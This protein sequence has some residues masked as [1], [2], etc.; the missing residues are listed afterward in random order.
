MLFF[1]PNIC[2]YLMFI[3][4][5]FGVMPFTL[6]YLLPPEIWVF[7]LPTFSP[8]PSEFQLCDKVFDQLE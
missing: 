6:K 7:F 4:T 2:W 3:V 1:A 5:C 8:F